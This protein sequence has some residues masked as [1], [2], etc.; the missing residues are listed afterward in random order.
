MF[1]FRGSFTK[2]VAS[3]VVLED[4]KYLIF[5]DLLWPCC[6]FVKQTVAKKAIYMSC[7]QQFLLQVNYFS[8]SETHQAI[9]LEF[10]L[11]SVYIRN[12][13]QLD[14]TKKVYLLHRITRWRLVKKGCD[15]DCYFLRQIK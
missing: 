11:F 5:S 3:A 14:Q 6:D 9:K 10:V 12:R 4:K 13:L 8:I 7:C 2:L 15:F 1:T